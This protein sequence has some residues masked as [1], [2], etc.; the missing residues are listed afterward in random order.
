MIKLSCTI[1]FTLLS[2]GSYLFYY[3]QGLSNMKIRMKKGGWNG[4]ENKGYKEPERY[5]PARIDNPGPLATLDE[6]N[7]GQ[8]RKRENK[9]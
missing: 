6:L 7:T 3:L 8:R 9:T 5:N 2:L 4:Y 1:L